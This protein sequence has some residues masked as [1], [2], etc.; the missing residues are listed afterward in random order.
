MSTTNANRIGINVLTCDLFVQLQLFT[1]AQ[2][3]DKN[4]FKKEKRRKTAIKNNKIHENNLS[5]AS[6][7][8]ILLVS[9]A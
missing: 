4:D 5:S 9:S 7:S 6:P 1:R 8:K 2:S 3:I